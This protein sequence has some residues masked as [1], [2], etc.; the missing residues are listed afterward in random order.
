MNDILVRILTEIN[1]N[2]SVDIGLYETDRHSCMYK[3]GC[4]PF[5]ILLVHVRKKKRVCNKIYQAI[6]TLE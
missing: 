1:I 3:R 5:P 2:L 6:N 4:F